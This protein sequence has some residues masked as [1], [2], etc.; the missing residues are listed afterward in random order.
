MSSETDG[1]S[2][3]RLPPKKRFKFSDIEETSCFGEKIKVG[4]EIKV[5]E[6]IKVEENQSAEGGN[7]IAGVIRHTS[8]PDHAVSYISLFSI[9]KI[10][11][12]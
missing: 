11:K 7:L 1:N 2:T 6:K 10:S 4:E 3:N 12:I 9:P 8:C 5:R